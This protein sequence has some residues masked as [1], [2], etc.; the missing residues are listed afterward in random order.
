MEQVSQKFEQLWHVAKFSSKVLAGQSQ[1]GELILF[2][3]QAV[4]LVNELVQPMHLKLHAINM[5][6]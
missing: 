4:Q 3:E 2:P 5:I 1:E 6:I